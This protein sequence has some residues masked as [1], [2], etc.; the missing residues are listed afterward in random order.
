MKCKMS[1][2]AQYTW[3][4]TSVTGSPL[5]SEPSSK[6]DLQSSPKIFGPLHISCLFYMNSTLTNQ[7]CHNQGW[8]NPQSTLNNVVQWVNCFW[9]EKSTLY[10][11]RGV[12]KNS[13]IAKLLMKIVARHKS[14]SSSVNRTSNWCAEDSCWVRVGSLS[15]QNIIQWCSL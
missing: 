14:P 4:V 7:F 10:G 12:P 13:T 3:S 9:R 15:C 11:G 1:S 8:N 2:G 6:Y 5:Y